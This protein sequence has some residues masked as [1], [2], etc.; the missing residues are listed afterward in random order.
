M[1]H[2]REARRVQNAPQLEVTQTLHTLFGRRRVVLRLTPR[3]EAHEGCVNHPTSTARGIQ[4]DA[5]HAL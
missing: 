5:T 2:R 4:L 3:R 1:R